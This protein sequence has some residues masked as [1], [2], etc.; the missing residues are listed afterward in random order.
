MYHIP[1]FGYGSYRLHEEDI[2]NTLLYAIEQGYRHID[3]ALLYSN[4]KYIS[5][6]L[7]DNKLDRS[8]LYI[9]SKIPMKSIEQGTTHDSIVK[10][11]ENLNTKKVNSIILHSFVVIEDKKNKKHKN[12]EKKHNTLIDN[13]S[14]DNISNQQLKYDPKL[15]QEIKA[16]ITLEQFQRQ[17]YIDHIGVSN[18][19]ET[20]LQI[21]EENK[22]TTPYLNQIELNPFCY[23]K[24]LINYCD[25]KDIRVVAHTPLAKAEKLDDTTLVDLSK[26]YSVSPSNIMLS[27][28]RQ[29][30]FITIPRS[31][32][33][34]H[35]LE[36][37]SYVKL[38]EDDMIVLD[39][40][41]CDYFTHAKYIV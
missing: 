34:E 41:N 22:L 6:V 8:S 1:S 27:W 38:E 25:K 13:T 2:S 30:G 7:D 15:T 3:T 10:I 28:C 11:I 36:N 4:E 21:F 19:N 9:N 29:H 20:H 23:R 35:L 40:M 39:N 17:G 12:Q 5:K 24:S 37:L 18:F 26:K 31:G 16:Y 33:K 14:S 32:K